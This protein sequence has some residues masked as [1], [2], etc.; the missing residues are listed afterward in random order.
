M[1]QIGE[2]RHLPTSQGRCWHIWWQCPSCG[3]EWWLREDSRWRK[4]FTGLCRECRGRDSMKGW[5]GPNHP[6]WK[7]GKRVAVNGYIY[8]WVSPESPFYT[9]ATDGYFAPEHR[10][11]MAQ[12]LGRCLQ[13]NEVVHHKNG[14]TTDNRLENLELFPNGN[15]DHMRQEHQ[16]PRNEKGQFVSLKGG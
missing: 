12:H 11:V 6:C 13:P 5:V 9:M 4:G 14:D 7:N 15:G 1:P 10:I 8:I 16:R 3:K 2:W